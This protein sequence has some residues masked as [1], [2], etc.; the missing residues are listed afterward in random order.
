MKYAL[1]PVLYFWPKQ[2]M[3]NFYQQAA[4]SDADLIYLGETVCSK[5]RELRSKDYLSIAKE[6]SSM[7]KQVVLSTMVL[8]EAP[9]EINELKRYCENGDFLVE[10]N[11][12]AAVQLLSQAKVPFVAGSAL[13]IYNHQTLKLLSKQGMIRWCIPVELS[14]DK[15]HAI[16]EQCKKIGI[17]HNFEIEVVGYGHLP[18]A[19]SARCFT[20]RSENR[21]KD[22]CGYC[23][24]NYPQGR[25]TKSQ[26]GE[27]LFVLN[28]IQTMSGDCYNLS[29]EQA[30]MHDLIDIFRVSPESDEAFDVIAK[31][32]QKQT[33]TK[34][35]NHTN[36][37]WHQIAGIKTVN[38]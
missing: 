27:D 28:G 12:M 7:G 3:M 21:T 30:Q 6:L 25:L 2:T 26:E 9:S 1:G 29:S 23:C 5:R 35:S 24:I 10:A 8:L 20:A 37:Y 16:V 18:L 32:K 17:R 34:M 33:I 11:D 22:E 19:Y 36:G 4:K 13:N 31:L 15:L 38:V 14:K